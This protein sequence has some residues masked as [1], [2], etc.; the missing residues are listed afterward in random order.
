M[1]ARLSLILIAL[2]V[3]PTVQAKSPVFE[4]R[5]GAIRGYDAVAYFAE[6]KAVKGNKRYALQ[7]GGATWYFANAGNRDRFRAEPAKY[8]P[9]YGGYCAYAVANGYTASTDPQAWSIVDGRLYLNFSTGVR[10]QW[11][12]DVPGHIRRANNNWPGVL[13]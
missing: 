7:W 8:A 12:Q 5:Q 4:T 6:G 9:Q 2:L 10:E 13:E 11:Q 1:L 3:V